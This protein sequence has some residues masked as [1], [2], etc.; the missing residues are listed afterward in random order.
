MHCHP[1]QAIPYRSEADRSAPSA[2]I[3]DFGR[4]NHFALALE[5]RGDDPPIKALVDK[6][7][8]PLNS[9]LTLLMSSGANQTRFRHFFGP[10]WQQDPRLRACGPCGKDRPALWAL[11]GR[12]S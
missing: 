12:S 5:V 7:A 1:S 6:M 2:C 9:Q 4:K 10:H 8:R 11:S 3:L